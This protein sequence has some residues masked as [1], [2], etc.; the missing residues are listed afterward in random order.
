MDEATRRKNKRVLAGLLLV[1][2]GMVGLAYASVPLYRLFCQ[3]T[4]FGGTTQ[5]AETLTDVPV[6]DRTVTVRFNADVDVRLP[7]AFE[8]PAEP[9]QVRLGEPAL[10]SYRARNL[11][12]R[13]V[14]GTAVFNV[15]PLKAGAYFTKVECFCFTEQRLAGGAEMDMPVYFYVDPALAEDAALDRVETITL[16]YTLYR[17]P[18][19][20][21]SDERASAPARH[22]SGSASVGTGL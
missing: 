8:A 10:V 18:S 4:G 17:D 5:R 6:L 14:V 19:D 22:Q 1:V 2:I 16:S 7:W 13:P 12:A 21:P 11:D 20:P 9:V 15:T 3:V